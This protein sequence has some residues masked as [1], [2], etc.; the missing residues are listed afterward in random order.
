[1][2]IFKLILPTFKF[3]VIFRGSSDSSDNRLEPKIETPL[4]NIASPNLWNSLYKQPIMVFA[5]AL[6]SV[7]IVSLYSFNPLIAIIFAYFNC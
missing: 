3:S 5:R 7:I 2:I 6:R 1:M 4:A